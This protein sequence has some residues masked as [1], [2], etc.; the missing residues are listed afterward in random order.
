MLTNRSFLILCPAGEVAF[1]GRGPWVDPLSHRVPILHPPA[2]ITT[3]GSEACYRPAMK[4][5]AGGAMRRCEPVELLLLQTG[6]PTRG[7]GGGAV[8]GPSM[9]CTKA[10]R[11]GGIAYR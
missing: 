2:R 1:V 6:R 5:L 3:H 4:S 11:G 8:E 7:G 10:R 9:Y